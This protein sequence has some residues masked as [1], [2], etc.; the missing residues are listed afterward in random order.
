M[1]NRYITTTSTT[2]I[3]NR[4]TTTTAKMFNRCTTTSRGVIRNPNQVGMTVGDFG[5]SGVQTFAKK[6][7]RGRGGVFYIGIYVYRRL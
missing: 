2:K 4:C 1:L 7:K 3:F 5:I 6:K